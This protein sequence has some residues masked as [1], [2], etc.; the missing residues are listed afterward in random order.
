LKQN[1]ELRTQ[2]HWT[3]FHNG[4]KKKIGLEPGLTPQSEFQT[5]EGS[6]AM[7]EKRLSHELA[8]HP[9]T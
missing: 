2:T 5:E 8:L 1:P 4:K 3:Q 7:L 9:Q 6:H